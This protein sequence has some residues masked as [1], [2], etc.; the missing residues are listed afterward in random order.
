VPGTKALRFESAPLGRV[1]SSVADVHSVTI[2]IPKH[3][4]ACNLTADFSENSP[5]EIASA[6]AVLFSADMRA[7]GNDIELKG[8][9]CQ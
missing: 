7:D 9:Q 2:R 5:L 3:L 6:L 1:I 4:E 8:G